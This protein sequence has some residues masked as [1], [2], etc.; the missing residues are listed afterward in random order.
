MFQPEME[1]MKLDVPFFENPG[2]DC[3][4]AAL[5]M[6]CKFFGLDVKR[7]VLRELIEIEESG[8]SWT[9]GIA[10]A[11]GELGLITSF[12][13]N[14]FGVNPDNYSLEYYQSLSEGQERSEGKLVHLLG[15]CRHA[16]VHLEERSLPLNEILSELCKG[17]VPIAL[18][19]WSKVCGGP[20]YIGHIVPI[21]GYDDRYVYVHN[22]GPDEPKAFYP[23]EREVFDRARRA[24]GT[25]E[26]LVFIGQE[27]KN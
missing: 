21:I 17:T 1:Q 24:V 22:P 18:I 13:T 7:E 23:I 16:G 25:D 8:A 6:V 12:C 26:D 10:A 2:L 5:E 15:R 4:P 11:S 9:I 27:V 19:D 14:S 3:G 20:S